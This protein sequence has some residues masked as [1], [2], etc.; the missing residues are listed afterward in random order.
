L[1]RGPIQTALMRKSRP[2][3]AIAI[4][5]VI[6]AAAHLDLHGLALRAALGVALGWVVWRS[7]SIFPAMVLHGL[8]DA[9]TVGLAAWEVHHLGAEGAGPI[10]NGAGVVR[11]IIGALLS[12]VGVWLIRQLRSREELR[13]FEVIQPSAS[14][15]PASIHR[16]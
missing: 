15:P 9:G 6:F 13:G 10:L 3:V 11:L 7:G 12:L 1:F 2:W 14:I 16:V 8:Y 5:A 4:G